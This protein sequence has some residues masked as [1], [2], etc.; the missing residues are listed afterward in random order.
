[1]WWMSPSVACGKRLTSPSRK[2]WSIPS[3]ESAMS[4]KTAEQTA[5]GS[6]KPRRWWSSITFRLTLLYTL[7]AAGILTVCCVLV[8]WTLARN[9]DH[10]AGQFLEDEVHDLRVALRDLPDNPKSL[11]AEI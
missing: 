4:L 8:Y 7:S 9:V 1:M 5:V 11:D 10:L 6:S 3:A 2:N